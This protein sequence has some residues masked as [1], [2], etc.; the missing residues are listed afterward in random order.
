[1][2]NVQSR[3]MKRRVVGTVVLTAEEI[4][5]SKDGFVPVGVG[6]VSFDGGDGERD[7]VV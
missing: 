7:V 5:Q 4:C 1:M 3:G 2:V 6:D